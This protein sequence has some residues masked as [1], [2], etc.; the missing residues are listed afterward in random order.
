[1]RTHSVIVLVDN[2]DAATA[3]AIQYARTL[4][5]D[6]LRAVHFDL[7]PWKTSMLVKAWG[8][9][10]FTSFPLDI[11]ECPDRRMPR[12]AL[13][14]AHQIL[15]D[16]DTELTVLIPRREY[17]KLWHRVLHDRS[18]G[19][20]SAALSDVPH[21]NVTIVPYHLGTVPPT[22]DAVKVPPKT[23]ERSATRSASGNGRAAYT[24]IPIQNLPA[25]RTR[26]AEIQP[27]E[28]TS[29]AG[30]VRAMRIQPWG[31]NPALE[32]VVA[33]ETGSIVVVFFG[34]RELGGVRLGTLLR[35]EGVVGEHRGTRSILNP[36]YTILA[37]PAA[38]ISPNHHPS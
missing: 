36:I 16:G 38:P 1:M 26:I 22:P 4:T 23:P 21:C 15:G 18:S 2:L 27:R 20:I 29:F 33:D 3:R 7:D 19:S 30:R 5:P 17:T 35:V 31:G 28:P 12:A 32:C 8:D 14:M 25:D 10:G 11:V 24:D 9:L 37:T 6:R 13:E 34:R